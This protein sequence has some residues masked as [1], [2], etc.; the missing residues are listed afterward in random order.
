[1]IVFTTQNEILVRTRDG[2]NVTLMEDVELRSDTGAVYRVPIGS[3]SDGAST[4]PEIWVKL[5]PFGD[6]W[7]AGVVHD[8]AYR[9]T[10]QRQLENGYWAPAMLNKDQADLLLLDCMSALG[11]AQGTKEAIYDGVRLF[12]WKAFSEDRKA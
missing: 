2:R 12:G 7:L 4:P 9:G 6:Y 11:V 10:L 5:P 1:M 8:A 3:E